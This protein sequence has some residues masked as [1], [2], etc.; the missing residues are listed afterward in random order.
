MEYEASINLGL[1]R[2]YLEKGKVEVAEEAA[3]LSNE[4]ASKTDDLGL[5]REVSAFMLKLYGST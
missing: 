3:K 1:A 4:K 2:Q 5:R